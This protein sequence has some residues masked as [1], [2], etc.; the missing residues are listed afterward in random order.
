MKKALIWLLFGGLLAYP[1]EGLWRIPSNGGWVSVFMLPVYGLCFWSV[2][3]INQIPK[4]YRLSMRWQAVIGAL[5][6]LAIEFLSG[7]VL[8]IWLGLGIWDYS[9][10]PWN[11]YGQICVLFGVF[12]FLLMP[13]NIWLEDRLN[14]IWEKAHGRDALYN[15]TL[16]QAYKELFERKK[17]KNGI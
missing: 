2:G 13:F 12:W 16:W 5:I 4:F 1:I 17:E 9:H 14:Y 8:N 15:Y 3:G 10:L 6:V 7:V 11:L